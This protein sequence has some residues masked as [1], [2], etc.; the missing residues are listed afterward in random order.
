MWDSIKYPKY[1]L[2]M[3]IFQA[4]ISQFCGHIKQILLCNILAPYDQYIILQVIFQS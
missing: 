4:V 3:L 1:L 2:N